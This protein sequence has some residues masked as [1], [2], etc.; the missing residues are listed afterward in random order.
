MVTP[1]IAIKLPPSSTPIMAWREL[2]VDAKLIAL[3][4]CVFFAMKGMTLLILLEVIE[5]VAA[6]ID[7]HIE[8]III[9]LSSKYMFKE[10]DKLEKIEI[11]EL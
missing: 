5:F 6:R 2:K 11:K 1:K 3:S 7:A 10:N 8:V 9:E 4:I